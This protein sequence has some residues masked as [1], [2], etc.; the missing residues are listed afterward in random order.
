MSDDLIKHFFGGFVRLHILY[1]AAKEPICGVDMIEELGRHGYGLSPG[2]LYPI[3][4]QLEKGGYLTCEKQV[5]GGRQRKNY[6]ITRDGRK[7]LRE[8]RTKLQE[9]VGEVIEDR[10]SMALT[11]RL[12]SKAHR[13]R[14]EGAKTEPPDS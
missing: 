6:T 4:H 9:L 10:D 11:K 14:D 8:A 2:T 3:M 7:L 1:H 13:N 12:R 5:V